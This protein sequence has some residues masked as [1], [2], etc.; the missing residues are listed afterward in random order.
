MVYV[1]QLHFLTLSRFIRGVVSGVSLPISRET[2]LAG[3]Q[4]LF[5]IAV[6]KLD[7]LLDQG[8]R[9]NDTDLSDE[10]IPKLREL[11]ERS[12]AKEFS[13]FGDPR[14]VVNLEFLLI[15]LLFLFYVYLNTMEL[16]ILFPIRSSFHFH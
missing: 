9:T 10:Y 12:G 16:R 15:L 11:V 2:G 13:C 14:I 6:I 8:P 3:K 7:L 1:I 4:K 5:V